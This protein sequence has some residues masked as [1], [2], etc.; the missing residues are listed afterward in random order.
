MTDKNFISIGIPVFNGEKTIL[1]TIDSILKQDYRNFEIII[2]DDNSNDESLRLIK[3]KY[4][5]NNFIKIYSNKKKNNPIDNFI[6]LFKKSSGNIFKWLAQDDILKEKD[7]LSK[8]NDKFNEGYNFI[9]LNNEVINLIDGT[10]LKNYMKIYD[11]TLN[12]KDFLFKSIENCGWLFYG[13]YSNRILKRNIDILELNSN[14]FS[15]SEG[16]LIH[17]NLIDSNIFYLY[18]RNV[19]YEIS[20][21]SS[22]KNLNPFSEL[23]SYQ[24]YI[25]KTL[26]QIFFSNKIKLNIKIS[27]FLFFIRKTSLH[28]LYL[29]IH[30]FSSFIKSVILSKWK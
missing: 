28:Y 19:I 18:D 25:F 27:F 14:Y 1:R 2:S 3:E 15:Y 17:K 21:T 26:S 13:F 9:F 11:N 16:I 30:L 23:L 12:Q 6:F 5:K 8:V 20:K 7:I 10:H 29:L 22:S 24:N 4:S